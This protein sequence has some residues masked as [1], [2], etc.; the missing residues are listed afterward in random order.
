MT[1]PSVQDLIEAYSRWVRD[2]TVLRDVG[3]YVEI[4]TPYLDRHND[5][6]QIYARRTDGGFELTDDE[7]TIR[8]LRLSNCDPDTPK[9]RRMMEAVLNGFGVKRAGDALT[10]VTSIDN[11]PERKHRLVQAMLAVNDMFFVAEANVASLFRE[12]VE[13]WLEASEVRF[14]PEVSLTG[15]SGLTH[16]FDF[17]IPKSKAWPER[18]V[19]AISNPNKQAAESYSFAWMDTQEARAEGTEAYAL[20][21]D[22]KRPPAAEVV[23]AL[24]EYKIEPVM[25]SDRNRVRDR[26]AA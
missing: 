23:Q 12:D 10:V 14:T 9:R 19:R 11:F 8:D 24:R 22:S 16:H 4:T 6:L 1:R 13:A 7:Y 26:L 21:N 5:H 25:W 20:L 3:D 17:V 2:N 18:V 15:R